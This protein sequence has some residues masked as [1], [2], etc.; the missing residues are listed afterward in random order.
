MSEL[1]HP[2][3]ADWREP[4]KAKATTAERHSAFTEDLRAVINRHSMEGAS[5]TPDYLLAEYL[6]DCLTAYG[7]AVSRRDHW[8]GIDPWGKRDDRAFPRDPQCPRSPPSAETVEP[9]IESGMQ[10]VDGHVE[11]FMAVMLGRGHVMVADATHLGSPAIWFG[12][13]GKGFGSTEEMGRPVA[14]GETIAIIVFEDPRSIDVVENALKRARE[15]FASK[16][17]P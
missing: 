10:R 7:T 13:G 14:D 12:R 16:A 17:A 4:E 1:K 5:N 15:R 6:R 8:F 11:P 2:A 3:G 9:P